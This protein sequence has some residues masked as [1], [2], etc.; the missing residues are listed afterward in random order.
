MVEM[1]LGLDETWH[2][3]KLLYRWYRSVSGL[4]NGDDDSF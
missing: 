3:K 4:Q 1:D 2:N